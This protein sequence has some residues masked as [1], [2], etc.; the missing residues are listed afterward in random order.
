MKSSRRPSPKRAIWQKAGFWIVVLLLLAGGGAAW[1]F[2]L[3][4]Q[5]VISPQAAAS[6]GTDYHTATVRRG[7]IQI[8]ASGSGTLVANKS[9]D[10][11]F[12]TRGTVTELDVKLG[13]MVKAGQVIARQGD[14]VTL[15]ANLTSAKLQLLQAQQT[16]TTLQ[17]NANVSLAQA[18]QNLLKAQQTYD[19]AVTTQQRSTQ[20]RCSQDVRIKYDVALAN[21]QAKFDS[22]TQETYGS[23]KYVAAK[24]AYETALANATYCDAYTAN[25][26]SNAQASLG[27]AKGALQQAQSTYDTLKAASGIDP[28][29]L[30]L[31]EAKVTALTDQ[32]SKAQQDLTGITLTAP[33]DGKII[34]LA[35][36]QGA[37]VDT[38]TFVTIADISHP[39]LQV[40]LDQ[41]DMGK[42]L[43]G[44]S[45]QV[46]FD[47][48]PDQ[49]F[50]G[51]VVQVTPELV[52]ANN[53]QVAQ[54]LVELDATQAKTL[55]SLPLGLNATVTI[56]DKQVANALLVPSQA[57]KDLG[58]QEYAVFVVGS[59]GQLRFTPVQVGITDSTSAEILSGLQAGEQV[60]TGTA[61][62]LNIGSSTG[63]SSN[64]SNNGGQNFGG[65]FN[66][67]R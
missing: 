63:T 36:N 44:A 7:S 33:M 20:P 52:S 58:N 38:S 54:G 13:D 30:A 26:Q 62:T 15:Q 21:A 12:S 17:Q 3:G 50:T 5:A 46:V 14:S 49:T 61:A 11:S 18:Y 2:L 60:S 1:Y 28:N 39:T 34:F 8:S 43:N 40:S 67:G 6:S 42:L 37:I 23:D 59:D 22:M 48:L 66:P 55:Q 31:D 24:S 56:I 45:A 16:L 32:L 9:I 35:A 10:M 19:T 65:G 41:T 64:Q 25:E 27:V 4:G 47:A 57:L 53:A 29:Q 51:K